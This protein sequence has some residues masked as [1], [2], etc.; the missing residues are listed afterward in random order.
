MY[1]LFVWLHNVPS[2]AEDTIAIPGAK[3]ICVNKN[4]SISFSVKLKTIQFDKVR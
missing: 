4:P 3:V 2:G 1:H